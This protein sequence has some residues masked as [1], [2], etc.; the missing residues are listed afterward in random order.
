MRVIADL[1]PGPGLRRLSAAPGSSTSSTEALY[2]CKA[3]VWSAIFSVRWAGV[4]H[5]SRA[6]TDRWAPAVYNASVVPRVPS[7]SRCD[8]L[9]IAR[10]QAWFL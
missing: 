7:S 1:Q 6:S 3:S 2:A 10:R 5:H 4:M 9:V 8:R